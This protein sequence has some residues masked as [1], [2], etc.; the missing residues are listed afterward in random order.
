MS[1]SWSSDSHIEKR[2]RIVGL[3]FVPELDRQVETI[4]YG[5]YVGNVVEVALM[6]KSKPWTIVTLYVGRSK[7]VSKG[8]GSV[9]WF[10]RILFN[11][12][13]VIRILSQRF[14]AP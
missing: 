14:M 2:K 8:F 7:F 4:E 13:K 5:S 9:A 11:A 12:L 3:R 6:N 10:Q 1:L